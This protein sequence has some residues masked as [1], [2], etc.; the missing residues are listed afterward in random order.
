MRTITYET[1]ALYGD[2][3]VVEVRRVLLEIPGVSEVFASSAFHLVDVTFDPA[4]ATEE[5]IREALEDM[6][7]MNELGTPVESDQAAHLIEDKSL[8]FFRH[9][10]VF[11]NS[12]DVVGFSQNVSYSGRPLWNCPGFGVIKNKMED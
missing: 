9:T 6:G 8:T 12:R 10:E 4:K 1:P 7:Y 3:H 5:K 2:H 11:E